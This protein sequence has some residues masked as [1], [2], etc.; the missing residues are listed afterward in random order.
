MRCADAGDAEDGNVLRLS[1]AAERAQ[2]GVTFGTV[3]QRTLSAEARTIRVVTF[4]E[5]RMATRR[6]S[7]L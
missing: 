5:M 2:F 7:G 1:R 6:R 4:D 3:D